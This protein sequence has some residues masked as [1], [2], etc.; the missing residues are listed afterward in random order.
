MSAWRDGGVDGDATGGHDGA[1]GAVILYQDTG[2]AWVASGEAICPV[3]AHHGVLDR[4]AAAAA[5]RGRRAMVFGGA[6][7]LAELPGT[8]SL[9]VGAEPVWDPQ[10]WAASVRAHRSLREKPRHARAQGV[11][12]RWVAGDQ[13]AADAPL[14][15]AVMALVRRWL[16]TRRMPPLRFLVDLAPLIRPVASAQ[17]TDAAPHFPRVLLAERAGALVGLLAMRPRLRGDG[18]QLDHLLR[19]PSAPN[20]TTTLL[21]HE[22]MSV[23]AGEGVRWASLGMVP[24]SGTAARWTVWTRRI[25]GALYRFD[26]LDAFKR[27]L[28]PT[29]W[30]P[31]YLVSPQ[32]TAPVM[33]L[34]DALRA[35]AGG[36]LWRFAM[37]TGRHRLTHRWRRPPKISSRP[38][39]N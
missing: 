23:L 30:E 29:R 24:L 13:M 22:A 12:T 14:R 16:A 36:S 15:Q 37:A 34:L 27:R 11:T 6:P 38:I 9:C 18:W 7:S 25:G 28:H 21:V 33:A 2:R 20:G 32:P 35:F 19:D 10:R 5:A 1:A 39:F 8:R 31:V 4:F 3:Q 17:A 26:G